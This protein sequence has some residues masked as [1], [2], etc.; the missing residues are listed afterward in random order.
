[1]YRKKGQNAVKSANL[2]ASTYAATHGD[3]LFD[4]LLTQFASYL[5]LSG[6]SFLL[7]VSRR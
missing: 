2:K 5:A 4:G 6:M 7:A 1:M 3:S